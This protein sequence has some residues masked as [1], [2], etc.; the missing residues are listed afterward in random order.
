MSKYN[1]LAIAAVSV[2][3]VMA[4]HYPASAQEAAAPPSVMVATAAE[5][6]VTP[7]FSYVGRIEAVDTVE[8]RARV[9]GFLEQRNF[10]EGGEVKAGDLLFVIEKAP[11]EVVVQQREAA[12]AGA[13]AT[14]VNAQVDLQRQEELVLRDVASEATLDSS[15]AIEGAA[16]AEVLKAE[17]DVRRAELDLSYTDI[18]SPI[19]GKVSRAEYSIGNLVNPGS[20]P[21]ARVTSVDPVYV[22]IGVS[23]KDLIEYRREGIDI[24]N[25]RSTPSLQLSDG[26]DYE[27]PGKFDYLDPEV[28]QSTDTVL[29]RAVFPNPDKV[30][31]PGQ[32][33]TVK[34]KRIEVATAIVVSQAA[35]QRDAEGYFVLIVDR[36]NKVEVRR[37]ETGN[38]IEGDWVV[39]S[40]LAAGESVIVQ[41]LQKVRPDMVVAPVAAS[42]G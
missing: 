26:S 15:R 11:Y 16:A 21:L 38:Q 42:G 29:V 39:Q 28:S 1:S 13:Q 32:F 12:L 4:A 6:D 10:R 33:V 34:I 25:P 31:L 3:L 41:G 27:H 8:L 24:D 7:E 37:I 5:R 30:L 40:G 2:F 23:E 18:F 9:E 36:A 19:D 20:G 17:A 35:V 22:T 14:L